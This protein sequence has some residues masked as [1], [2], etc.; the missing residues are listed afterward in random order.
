MRAYL[1]EETI[2]KIGKYTFGVKMIAEGGNLESIGPFTISI[3]LGEI[4]LVFPSV[5]I[6]PKEGLSKI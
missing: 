2:V 5:L 1:T 3:V 4:Q 6:N